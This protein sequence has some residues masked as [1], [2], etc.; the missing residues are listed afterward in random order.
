M[1]ASP[2]PADASVPD[3]RAPELEGQIRA[4]IREFDV[5]ALL[6]LLVSMGYQTSEIAFRGHLSTSPQPS[7]LHDIEFR[8]PPLRSQRTGASTG[9]GIGPG[10]EPEITLLR[11][12]VAH[13]ARVTV[14]VNLGL[15]SCRSPLPSYFQQLFYDLESTDPVIELLR[16]LDRPLLHTRL[17]SDTADRILTHW[18]DVRRD[19]VRIHGLGSPTGLHWL[20]RHVFP[21]LGVSVRRLTDDYRVPYHAARLGRSNLGY[22]TFG[23]ISRITVHDLEVALVSEEGTYG[24]EPWPRVADRRI[25]RFIL[26][27]L[28]EVCMNLTISF[29]LLDRDSIARIARTSYVGYDPMWDLLDGPPDEHL[30]PTRIVLYR[31]ALPRLEPDADDLEQVVATDQGAQI[32]L[33]RPPSVRNASTSALPESPGHSIRMSL[34][35]TSD[36]RR[37]AYEVQVYWGSRSWY[38]EQPHEIQLSFQGLPK[39]SVTEHHHPGLWLRLR[40]DARTRV[41]NRMAI[42]I[43]AVEPEERVTERLVARL[44]EQDD[45]ERLHAL[46]W[47]RLDW[48]PETMPEG[49]EHEPRPLPWDPAAWQ[50]YLEWAGY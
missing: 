15:L 31:G 1:P 12:R 38:A 45:A 33:G 39:A 29:V 14:C 28:D 2:T 8:R 44:C 25:R 26:P 21:E 30:P 16:L 42:E 50:R 9:P 47:S 35:Y 46:L 3:P 32:E 36:D 41:A 5:T 43:M 22:C 27:W 4:R 6:D 10:D 20:F 19:F 18:D 17:A 24:Q 13:D 11:E 48:S 49:A 40:D 37:W 34:V 7:L 23:N